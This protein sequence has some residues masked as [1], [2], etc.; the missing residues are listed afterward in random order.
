MSQPFWWGLAHSQ[1]RQRDCPGVCMRISYF[2]FFFFVEDLATGSRCPQCWDRVLSLAVENRGSGRGSSFPSSC[3]RWETTPPGT[4]RHKWYMASSPEGSWASRSPWTSSGWTT[5]PGST[6][7]GSGGPEVTTGG[8]TSSLRGFEVAKY[9]NR[10]PMDVKNDETPATQ[11][12]QM[13]CPNIKSDLEER[14]DETLTL[15]ASF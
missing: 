7:W 14:R 1:S 6:V 4:L 10:Y 5:G 3:S 13:G 12:D 8:N 11:W 9:Q 2:F 15:L